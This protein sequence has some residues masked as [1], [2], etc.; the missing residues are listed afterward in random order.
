ML[1]AESRGASEKEICARCLFFGPAGV[2]RTREQI[3]AAW[4]A[5]SKRRVES[6]I[7][8]DPKVLS[9]Y[10]RSYRSETSK[11]AQIHV[12]LDGGV[13]QLQWV[14]P[15]NTSPRVPLSAVRDTPS[16]GWRMRK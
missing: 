13:L 8:L 1:R 4:E 10:V 14:A 6:G 9:S 3:V 16:L 5:E 12:T 15:D 2:I 7:T 11:V